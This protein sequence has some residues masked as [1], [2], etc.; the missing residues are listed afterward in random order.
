MRNAARTVS[1]VV[2]M[3][4]CLPGAASAGR[5]AK[6]R[7]RN[8]AVGREL[9]MAAH[10]H[11][12]AVHALG[13]KATP[14]VAVQTPNRTSALRTGYLLIHPDMDGYSLTAV[15]SDVRHPGPKTIPLGRLITA[16]GNAD[17][18]EIG[19]AAI[20][21]SPEL[22]PKL[23]RQVTAAWREAVEELATGSK[24]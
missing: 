24:R 12:E 5:G 19:A 1:I 17:A 9:I 23:I 3:A 2:L 4:L 16:Q 6:E 11:R 8:E 20:Q 14:N 13:A 18:H 15:T 22:R 21:Q 10:S 7:R